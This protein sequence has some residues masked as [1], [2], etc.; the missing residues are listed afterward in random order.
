LFVLPV[1][2]QGRYK[3]LQSDARKI[4]SFRKN[5]F[6]CQQF[7]AF[8][9]RIFDRNHGGSTFLLGGF[10]S[11]RTKNFEMLGGRM[12]FLFHSQ[13]PLH[14]AKSRAISNAAIVDAF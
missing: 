11:T 12:G 1:F 2:A 8:A 5:L 6:T 10:L 7:N 14:A 13:A 3:V 4:L 9:G